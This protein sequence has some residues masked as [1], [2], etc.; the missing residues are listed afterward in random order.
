M[1]SNSKIIRNWR[2]NRCASESFSSAHPLVNLVWFL[3]VIGYTMFITHPFF[4]S[5]ALLS[6]F[7]YSILVTGNRAL[8][9][10]LK[11][12]LPLFI[13]SAGLNPI[14]NHQGATIITYFSD[15]NPLTLESIVWGFAAAFMFISVLMWFS[16]YNAIMTSD[17][18][19]YLFG[20]I[21]PSLSLVLSMILRFVPRYIAQIKIISNS[22]RCIGRDFGKGGLIRRVKSALSIISIMTTWALENGVDTA[23]SMKARGHGLSGRTSFSNFRFTSRDAALMLSMAVLN[24]V[25][26]VGFG[27][28]LVSNRYFIK[29][30][31]TPVTVDNFYVFLSFLFLCTLPMI[32]YISE[33]MKWRYLKLKS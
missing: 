4:L 8:K 1:S 28:H 2:S 17:K 5:V 21:I 16:C 18:I 15:G 33:E 26:L 11:F 3:S 14:F 10:N 27:T 19:I 23:D 32:L 9:F 22:Q 25:I 29:F 20:R 24:G 31:F 13:I 6:S 30:S 12:I 7:S